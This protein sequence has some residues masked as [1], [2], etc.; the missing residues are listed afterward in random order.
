M[1]LIIALE[2]Q[3][4]HLALM[5]AAAP[6]LLGLSRWVEGRLA[7]R[8]GAPVIQPWRD[9]IRLAREQPVVAETASGF[10][11]IAPAIG[12]AMTVVVAALVPS[13][14]LG[15]AAAPFA[16]LIV[17][18]GLL[19]LARVVVAL[20]AIESGT[21]LGGLGGGR[22][23]ALTAATEPPLLLAIFCLALLAG[24]SNLDAMAAVLR[25]GAGGARLP[26]VL[27]VMALAVVAVAR[28]RAGEAATPVPFGEVTMAG[29]A[30]A[31]EYSGRALALLRWGE[32]LRRLVWLS[33]L[34]DLALP[35]GLADSTGT[36]LSWLLGLV[37]WAAKV[38][39]LTLGLA[40]WRG[41]NA[42]LGAAR[43]ER[44]AEV[45]GIGLLLVLLAAAFLFAGQGPT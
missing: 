3:L 24:T 1:S 11:E 18:A 4:L 45:L 33:L 8:V 14:A 39:G 10:H 21:A 5:L 15:M 22:A 6:L 43:P 28:S 26:L 31:L 7:G 9:L 16:D 36:P 32:W 13:F 35:T 29:D 42:G 25:G 30:L 44:L 2:V 34:A 12:F 38:G 17:V 19:L 27:A 40:L 41:A 20:A 37:A 23:M